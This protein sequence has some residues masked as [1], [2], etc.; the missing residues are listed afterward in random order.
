MFQSVGKARQLGKRRGRHRIRGG[1][2]N[3]GAALAYP[4]WML[5]AGGLAYGLYKTLDTALALFGRFISADLT[6]GEA[7]A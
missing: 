4:L 6:E 1:Q 3:S 2:G 5:V 7:S